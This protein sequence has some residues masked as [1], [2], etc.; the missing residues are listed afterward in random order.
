MPTVRR[1]PNPNRPIDRL[2]ADLRREFPELKG[3]SPRTLKYMRA[4][5]NVYSDEPFVQQVAARLPW[6]CNVLNEGRGL[7]ARLEAAIRAHLRGLG[8]G[9]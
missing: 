4:F 6:G 5:A 3:F 1:I 8:R 7:M 9:L 2:A